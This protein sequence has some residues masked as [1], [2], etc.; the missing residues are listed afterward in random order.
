MV[1]SWSDEDDSEG[2]LENESAKHLTAL[3]GRFM[4]DIESC[5]G[6]S[7][8]EELAASYKELY[9]ISEEVCMLL[10]KQKNTIS[11]LHVERSDHLAKISNLNDEVTQLNS[12]LEHLKKQVR[13]M[14]TCTNL[15]E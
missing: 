2:E 6:E 7:T 9:T 15:L 12:Q 3:T 8:Y 1:V 13:M 4:Y 5:D 10:G 14:N 11:Q